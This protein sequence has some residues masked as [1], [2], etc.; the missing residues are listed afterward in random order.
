[1]R[2]FFFGIIL[3]LFFYCC[4][5]NS[6][7]QYQEAVQLENIPSPSQHGGESNLFVS[8]TG[9]VYLSWVEYLNDS[10]DALLF[11]KLEKDKWSTPIE[12]ANGNNWFVNWADF[13]SLVAYSDGGK[14][15]AAHWLQKSAGGTY[16][17]DVRIAQSGDGG[18]TWRNSFIPHRDSIAAEH[19][20]VTMFPIS[21]NRIF[22][23]WLDG[24]NTKVSRQSAVGSKQKGHHHENG[25]GG[26]MTLR[27][28]EFDRGGNLYEEAELDN[29]ICDCCQ[30][31]ATMTSTGPVVVY[32]DR[33]EDEVRDISIVRKVNGK[34]TMPKSIHSD[35]WKITGCPVNGPAISAEGNVLAVAWFTAPDGKGKVNVAFSKDAGETFGQPIQVDEGNPSG[36]VDIILLSKNEVLVTWLE[37]VEDQAEIRAAKVGPENKI[38]PSMF[39]KETSQSRSS[40]FPI[41]VKSGENIYMSWTE[42]DS[43]TSVQTVR[44]KI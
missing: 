6:S 17:Y 37:N 2:A 19:G 38:G 40:G 26:A 11:S 14:S 12:I 9:Q 1:M 34:W 8:E 43:L 36:R 42:V 32:R 23:T 30:T 27:T 15:L 7:S 24:R 41:M 35:N 13:P 16:D 28:A 18:Q 3:L 21:E 5:Q 33:S 39:L 4:Q 20:F 44:I 10:T 29:R 31:D 22:A 25:H